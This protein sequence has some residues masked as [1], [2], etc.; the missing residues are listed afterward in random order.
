[1]EEKYI[2]T[3][4][5]LEAIEQEK[6]HSQRELSRKLNISLGTVNKF[7]NDLKNQGALDI[8]NQLKYRVEYILT[9]KGV[10]EKVKLKIQHIFHSLDFY[11]NMKRMISDRLAY[12]NKAGYQNLIF[13]GA[14]EL[15]EIAC[16]LLSQTNNRTI[17]II[18]DK[19]AGQYICGI[20]ICNE[21]EMSNMVFDGIVLMEIDTTDSIRRK[22]I[23]KGIPSNKILSIF[24]TH[25]R[26]NNL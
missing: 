25:L 18:N 2:K 11:N 15:C 26:P 21:K 12:L 8:A 1:M 4:I 20:K 5:I 22:L 13:Y 10:A 23:F 24:P 17:K 7:I 19:K 14:G 16:I 6:N 9:P 3:L